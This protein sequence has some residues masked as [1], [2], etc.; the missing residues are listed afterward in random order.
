MAFDPIIECLKQVTDFD[1]Y[2]QFCIDLLRFDGYTTIEP[3]GGRTDKNR[4]AVLRLSDESVIFH[5]SVR[6]DWKTKLWEDAD[7]V[8]KHQHLCT[9][10]VYVNP[11]EFST[12]ARDAC[13]AEFE[14]A[15]GLPLELYGIERMASLLRT[16]AAPL[17]HIYP[18]IF[19]PHLIEGYRRPTIDVRISP[20]RDRRQQLAQIVAYNRGPGAVLIDGW[21]ACWDDGGS[22]CTTQSIVSRR[23]KLPSRLLDKEKLDIT[24]PLEFDW[25]SLKRLGVIDAEKGLHDATAGNVESFLEQAKLHAPPPRKNVGPTLEQVNAQPISILLHVE[26]SIA[27]KH[28]RLVLVFRNDGDVPLKTTGA[29]I[30]WK[31]DTSRALAANAHMPGPRA[32]ESGASWPLRRISPN[33]GSSHGN[34]IRFVLDEGAEVLIDLVTRESDVTE[35]AVSVIVQPGF[36][37]TETE[38]VLELAKVVAESVLASWD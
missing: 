34:E 8:L 30:E 15:F 24:V 10:V 23:G 14:E 21:F 33:D 29:L 2:E 22:P 28:D 5:Y 38:N 16:Q 11:A 27:R 32:V 26:K 7:G 25:K 9:K 4:D 20:T 19:S 3:L 6:K 36:V 31:F 17:L 35:V 13:I 37:I 12:S 1:R 18:Q